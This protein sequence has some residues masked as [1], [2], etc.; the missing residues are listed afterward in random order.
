LS[1]HAFAAGRNIACFYLL[2]DRGNAH[3]L[4]L[5]AIEMRAAASLISRRFA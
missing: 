4:K 1:V 5:K 3:P 2:G